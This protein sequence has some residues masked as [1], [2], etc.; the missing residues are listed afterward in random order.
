MKG[1]IMDFGHVY[2]VFSSLFKVR[3]LSSTLRELEMQKALSAC[4]GFSSTGS[5]ANTSVFFR[6]KQ[7]AP[8]K[9]LFKRYSK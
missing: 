8:N 2:I 6:M 3:T 1:R 5:K 4:Y 9:I 7:V